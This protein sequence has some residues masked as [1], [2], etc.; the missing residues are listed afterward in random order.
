MKFLLYCDSPVGRLALAEEDDQL[1]TVCF[2]GEK[3]P[4]GAIE[5]ETPLLKRTVQQLNEYFAGVRRDFDLPLNPQGT[6]FQR[7]VWQALCTIP[8]GET[9]SYGDIASHIGK[10]Q[11]ARA[12]G[13]ANNRNPIAIIIPCHRVIGSS[14]TLVGYGGGLKR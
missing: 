2:S 12:V 8:Y 5:R 10:P 7:A 9:R 4:D 3:L 13:G 14:G 11:A 6:D 1:L